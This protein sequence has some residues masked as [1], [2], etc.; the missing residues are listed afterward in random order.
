MWT[1]TEVKKRA[2]GGL[3][4]YYWKAVALD[5][6]VG[7]MSGLSVI[8]CALA[9]GIVF[10]CPCLS[11]ISPFISMIVTGF[12][13]NIIGVG[14]IKYFLHSIRNGESGPI[15]MVFSGF[16][17]GHY[18]NSAKILTFRNI[19][20][21]LW[22]LLFCIP[23]IIKSY[24]YWAIPYLIA[25]YPEKTQDE[26]FS[27]SKQMTTGNK[28]RIFVFQLSLI[29]WSLLGMVTFGLAFFFIS[30][31]LDAAFTE[32]YLAI[33]EERLG[34]PRDAA[35]NGGSG[36]GN[37]Y[38]SNYIGSSDHVVYQPQNQNLL[39]QNGMVDDDAPTAD[40]YGGS[41]PVYGGSAQAFGR[42]TLVGVQGEYAGASIPI[43][44]GQKLIVGRDATR[45]NVILSSPQVSRLHMTVEYVDGK[46]IVVD[47]STY[48]THDLNQ[49]QLPKE[50]SVSVPAGTTL[51]LGNGDEVFRLELRS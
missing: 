14:G 9:I 6:I 21:F 17:T 32:L 40:I 43:E 38:N 1:I 15:S 7:F 13:T 23:G 28:W 45:C 27:L 11:P 20:Q 30:P 25:D 39:P 48:G 42:P 18:G 24:E 46:F 16:S 49:G 51:R 29:G 36:S 19:F 8:P 47:Y 3:K 4:N 35:Q 12:Y 33:R 26:I 37:G 31:Y 22:S 10:V 34:I 41:N 2:W 50:T 5:F 44:P